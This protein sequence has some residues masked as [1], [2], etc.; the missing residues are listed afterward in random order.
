MQPA[1]Q[2]TLGQKDPGFGICQNSFSPTGF[3]SLCKIS[4]VILND[5]LARGAEMNHKDV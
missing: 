3:A 2:F 1:L 4:E 5:G